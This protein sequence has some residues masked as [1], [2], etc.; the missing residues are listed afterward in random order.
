MRRRALLG[1]S[2]DGMDLA[3]LQRAFRSI[4][5]VT[6]ARFRPAASFLLIA[7]RLPQHLRDGSLIKTCDRAP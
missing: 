6:S 5:K 2:T 3:M 4:N 1:S 7:P